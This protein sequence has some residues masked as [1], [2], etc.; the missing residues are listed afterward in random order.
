MNDLRLP[1][2]RRLDDASLGRMFRLAPSHRGWTDRVRN[3][4]EGR[5]SPVR[6]L[7]TVG[8]L[9]GIHPIS[10][11][12]PLEVGSLSPAPSQ[13]RAKETDMAIRFPTLTLLGLSTQIA[14]TG[15]ALADAPVAAWG[16]NGSGQVNAPSGAFRNIAV[17][18]HFYTGFSLAVRSDGSIAHW[19]SGVVAAVPSGT[20]IDVAGCNLSACALRSDGTLVWWGSFN[21]SG[22]ANVPSGSFLDVDGAGANFAARRANGSWLV[23]GDDQFGQVS[24][25]PTTALAELK[26]GPWYLLA[27][28]SNG[29]IRAWGNVPTQIAAIPA[30]AQRSLWPAHNH[31]VALRADGT[32]VC[33][34]QN[35]DG[36]CDAPGGSFRQIAAGGEQRGFTIGLRQDGTA[37]AWGYNGNSECSVPAVPLSRI[38]V[39]SFHGVGFVTDPCLADI[40]GNGSVDGVDLA[41]VLGSWGTGGSKSGADLDGDG[42]V[43]G[44]D[45]AIVLSGWGA[46]P[47]P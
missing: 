26:V 40:T 35:I 4:V 22:V 15:A 18:G 6:F 8:L 1:E 31:A 28:E 39:G 16:Y 10:A 21:E 32:A 12:K 30:G 7:I 9:L 47:L 17:G 46:C 38:V 14:L 34:G 42:V 36:E 3:K 33:W 27:R 20:F 29:A 19:G 43:G 13:F 23:W 25:A 41:A 24:A 45:L 11:D 2:L 5:S 44:A 37:V